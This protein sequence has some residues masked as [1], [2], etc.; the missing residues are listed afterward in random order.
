M[1]RWKEEKLWY[2]S[3][4]RR[5]RSHV[6]P[7]RPFPGIPW[8]SA[9]CARSPRSSAR[10]RR[11]LATSYVSLLRRSCTRPRAD[12]S[13]R[14][15]IRLPSR[16]PPS[17][18]TPYHRTSPPVRQALRAAPIPPYPRTLCRLKSERI[19]TEL[20]GCVVREMCRLF[21]PNTRFRDAPRGYKRLST[22]EEVFS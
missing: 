18:R 14:S 16:W 20:T 17:S 3:P 9:V 8:P 7:S 13:L 4:T 1:K 21:D 5:S 15:T 12:S 22:V 2:H 6:I 19:R 10:W 11:L